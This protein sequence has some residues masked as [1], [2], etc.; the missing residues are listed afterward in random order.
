MKKRLPLLLLFCA[1]FLSSCGS[2]SGQELGFKAGLS[3]SLADFSRG[4]PGITLQS[5]NDY[6][7]GIFISLD[8]FGGQLGLQ[9]EVNYIVKGFDAREMDRGAKI[10][11]QYKISYIEVPFLVYYRAPLKGRFKPGV[12]FGPY[13]GFAHKVQEVQT[14][15]GETEKRALDDNLKGEDFGLVFGGNM[16]YRVGFINLMLDIRYSLGFNNISQDIMDVAYEF[17]QDDEI[18]NR[19]LVVSLGAGLNLTRKKDS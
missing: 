17:R 12:C 14:A 5:M 15:F 2:L 6:S 11:S 1:V 19:A 8:L 13:L 18:K 7:A 10:S 4:L 9:P 3:R 16:K